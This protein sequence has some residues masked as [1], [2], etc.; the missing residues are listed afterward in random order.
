[1]SR[2]LSKKTNFRTSTLIPTTSIVQ[3]Q[4]K[5]NKILLNNVAGHKQ[6]VHIKQRQQSTNQSE[7][8]NSELIK[9]GYCDGKNHIGACILTG[10]IHG[11]HSSNILNIFMYR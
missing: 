5:K 6:D 2:S 7:D 10:A 3:T 4:D 11:H 9:Q 8:R 1:M